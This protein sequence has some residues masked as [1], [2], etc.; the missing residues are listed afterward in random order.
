M[1]LIE[2]QPIYNASFTEDEID[3]FTPVLNVKQSMKNINEIN[4]PTVVKCCSN[5]Y[6][7]V[8]ARKYFRSSSKSC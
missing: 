1:D 6:A 3:N 2:S 8:T 7:V 5:S 4:L